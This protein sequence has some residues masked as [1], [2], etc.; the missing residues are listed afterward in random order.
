MIGI[1]NNRIRTVNESAK[2]INCWIVLSHFW[3]NFSFDVVSYPWRFLSIITA[4]NS[5][6]LVQELNHFSILETSGTNWSCQLYHY[7]LPSL[8][9]PPVHTD[10]EIHF[11]NIS[12]TNVWFTHKS[13]ALQKEV[14]E[15][16][17]YAEW[18]SLPVGVILQHL[19][20]ECS[21]HS[22]EASRCLFPNGDSSKMLKET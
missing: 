17:S 14:K 16:L 22:A 9:S 2:K 6:N 20:V 13:E 21:Q 3:M 1:E 8:H 12:S 19:Q 7:C 11:W 18:G 10:Y 4:T 5:T 15:G